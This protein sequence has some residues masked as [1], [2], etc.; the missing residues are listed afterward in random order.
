MDIRNLACLALAVSACDREFILEGE[1]F[2][3]RAPFAEGAGDAPASR[4]APIRLPATQVNAAWTHRLG[5][6][7]TRIAH[8]ALGSAVSRQWAATHRAG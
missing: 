2:P 7:N 4:A 3:L 5:T 8:P 1:R 6:P